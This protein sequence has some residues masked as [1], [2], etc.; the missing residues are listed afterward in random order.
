[1]NEL[2]IV[3][4]ENDVVVGSQR[5][6]ALDHKNAIYRVAG[7]WVFNSS[8]QVLLAQRSP[9]K[10]TGPGQWSPSAG[11][12]VEVGESYLEN[13]IKEADEEIGLWGV[14]LTEIDKYFVRQLH[15]FFIQYFMTTVDWPAEQ[16]TLQPEEVAQ[17]KWMTI[18]DLLRDVNE[19]PNAYVPSITFGLRAL[20]KVQSNNG[21]S[22]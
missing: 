21:N 1:M 6:G 14:D 22:Q 2:I 9:N 12:T 11:G 15:S 10:L 3:V 17:V 8:G 18:E 5:R 13:I 7:L 20:A 4:D 19:N 16:F